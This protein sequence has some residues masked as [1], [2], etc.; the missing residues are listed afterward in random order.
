LG[1]KYE[2]GFDVKK[3]KLRYAF[4][5]KSQVFLLIFFFIIMVYKGRVLDLIAL[6]DAVMQVVIQ[7]KNN[8]SY[9][10]IA[11]IA[12]LDI[13]VLIQQI[14]IE[15]GDVVKIHYYIKSKKWE[16]KYTTNAI[17]EKILIIE[18]KPSQQLLVDLSTGEILG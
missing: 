2:F 4:I 16:N 10:P 17:I 14:R 1:K 5:L 15:K 6:T 8:E 18:K 9:F 13:R 12:F 7:V 3:I 11:F